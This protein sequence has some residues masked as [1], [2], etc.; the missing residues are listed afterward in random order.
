MHRSSSFSVIRRAATVAGALALGLTALLPGQA[1]ATTPAGN[2]SINTYHDWDGSSE[3]IAFGCPDTTTY[4]QVITMPGHQTRINKFTFQLSNYSTGSM[5]V[6]GE[7]YAW[8]GSEATGSAIFESAPRTIAY[9]DAA[10][11]AETFNAHGVHVK[12]GGQYVV[13]ASIDKD[14]EQCTNDYTLGWGSVDDSTYG[15]GTFVYQNNSGDESQWTT[16]PWDTFGIDLAVK[17]NL[18]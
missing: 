5:V 11:H 17:V 16:T 15:G 4:G 9:Q 18:K 10:F 3:V 6:R 8:D 12:M 14:Y 2:A 7:I 1:S 13:F